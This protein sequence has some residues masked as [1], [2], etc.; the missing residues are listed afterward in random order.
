MAVELADGT[1]TLKASERVA[2]KIRK[3]IVRGKLKP[4]DHLPPESE[5]LPQYGVSRPTLREAIRLVE[6]EGLLTIS[7]G[8]R[9]GPQ[10]KHPTSALIAKA[11]GIA[12]QIQGATLGDVYQ[13][14]LLIEPLA[15]RLAAE[16]RP[17]EAAVVL[18]AHVPAR[19]DITANPKKVRRD[20]ASF[21]HRLMEQ[22][23]NITL[24]VIGTALSELMARHNIVVHRK[25]QE[26]FA[27][28]RHAATATAKQ[29]RI[30]IR[31]IERLID[32][33]ERGRSDEAEEH[34]RLHMRNATSIWPSQIA[35]TSV[36]DILD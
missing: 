20:L 2:R 30:G 8:A 35:D 21:H 9:R 25:T 15:A 12:L 10:V 23:G 29:M 28:K 36:V 22:S 31:S 3:L 27:G 18:R 16:R 4:G 33:I 13:T 14:R 26:L 7:Q 19:S 5:M 1:Q 11:A 24:G 17:K 32:F 6:A 34:W